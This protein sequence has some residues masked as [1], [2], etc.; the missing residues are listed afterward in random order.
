MIETLVA[1]SP[2]AFLLLFCIYKFGTRGHD[3]FERIGLPYVKPIIFFGSI[4]DFLTKPGHEEEMRRYRKFGQIYGYFEG[5]K[6]NLS[7]AD[8]DLVKDVSIKN[9]SDF[10]GR[11]VLFTGDIVVDNM[12]A[13][14]RG[15]DWKRIRIIVSKTFTISKIKNTMNIFKSCAEIMVQNFR[16]VA[17]EENFV[18]TKRIFGAFTM[19]VIARSAFSTMIDSHNDPDNIF[20]KYAKRILNMKLGIKFI[21]FH[22]L[23]TK[24]MKLLKICITDVEATHALKNLAFEIMQQRRNNGQ[25]CNDFLQLLMD[26]AQ[27]YEETEATPVRTKGMSMDE[28]ASQAVAFLLAGY[29]TTASTLSFAAY[30][31]ALN[32]SVQDKLRDEVDAVLEKH[33]GELT[34][35]AIQSMTYMKSVLM[36]TLRLYPPIYR[37]ERQANADCQLGDTGITV[38]KGMLITIPIYAM[39]R[40]PNYWEDPDTFNP[41]RFEQQTMGLINK[42]YPHFLPFGLG[43]KSCVGKKFAEIEVKVCLSYLLA[44]F[45]VRTCSETK[46]PIEFDNGL[47]NLLQPL[48][49]TLRMEIRENPPVII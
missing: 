29:D 24:L 46:I 11:R 7:V 17:E 15:E 40:D 1:Y 38:R 45:K 34:Y 5:N 39:N 8:P 42:T 35:E 49:I 41:D 25:V 33:N 47:N 22:T 43:P 13:V 37:L 10:N 4:F 14:I 27:E 19:D 36:E 32:E 31:L 3:Y 2:F 28:L 44:N 16:V 26:A 23:P 9:F 12:V 6:A 18:D 30:L 20:V 21:C 48:D